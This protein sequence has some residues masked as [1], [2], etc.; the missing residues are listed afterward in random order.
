MINLSQAISEFVNTLSMLSQ[1]TERL[2]SPFSWPTDHDPIEW[3]DAQSIYP[4]FYW[5]SRD[6]NEE[7]IALGQVKTFS[8]PMSAEYTLTE[9]Q[10]IWGGCSFDGRTECGQCC[11]QSFFFLPQIEVSRFNE[12]WFLSINIGNDL[13]KTKATLAK[14]SDSFSSLASPQCNIV[15]MVHKPD[16]PRWSEM[17]DRALTDIE[18]TVLRKVVLARKTT[19]TLDRPLSATQLLKASRDKNSANFHFMLAFDAKHC[20]VGSTPERLFIRQEEKLRTE[21]LAGTIGRGI[22]IED[23]L[24]LSHWLLNDPKNIYENKLVVD[25]IADQLAQYCVSFYVEELPHLV[26]L[27]KVQHLKRE[28]FV[29]LNK[30]ILSTTLLEA[31]QPTAAI[32]GLPRESAMSFITKNEP[33]IRG[34]YS[35]SVGF[36]SRERSEFCVA[37]R[38]AFVM[39]NLIHL[40]AGA[41]IVPGSSPKIEWNELDKKISTLLCLLKP[42]EFKSKTTRIIDKMC[43]ERWKKERDESIPPK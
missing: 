30:D 25:D 40:F 34:W 4:K 14:L 19:L 5:H 37:I 2:S 16:Y 26:R 38:S 23:D 43:L 8:N 13:L 42:L 22:T 32:A 27:R 18:Y 41:G 35:G 1:I 20:F 11:F 12:Q 31:L 7:T 36:L 17:I 33:F 9:G 28:I 3:L 39:D 24:A 15:K 6:G 10:F 21:A 29:Q